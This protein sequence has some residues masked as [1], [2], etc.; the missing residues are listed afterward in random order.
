ML[1]S[2]L[3]DLQK[4]TEYWG[5]TQTYYADENISLVQKFDEELPML[6]DQEYFRRLK[7]H[8]LK[9]RIHKPVLAVLKI[10]A[11][12]WQKESSSTATQELFDELS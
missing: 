7:S 11:K 8:R 3:C 9:K 10:R 1:D 4:F 2:F 5:K 12:A 6:S